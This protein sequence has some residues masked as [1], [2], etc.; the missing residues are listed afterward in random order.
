MFDEMIIRRLI[1]DG[2][3]REATGDEMSR[4]IV[5]SMAGGRATIHGTS[6]DDG[7]WDGTFRLDDFDR[8]RHAALALFECVAADLDMDDGHLTELID[9]RDLDDDGWRML[10]AAIAAD[11]FEGS[12]LGE[13]HE[14]GMIEGD[15]VEVHFSASQLD[16]LRESLGDEGWR[17][18]VGTRRGFEKWTP[19][20]DNPSGGEGVVIRDGVAVHWVARDEDV[21]MK[22]C[23][24]SSGPEAIRFAGSPTFT[25]SFKLKD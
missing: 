9:V 4:V 19:N 11:T 13:L 21:Y 3:T 6:T 8:G 20:G 10:T 18:A 5:A 12:T 24:G 17:V 25:R 14:L 22:P 15:V 23:G 7:T 1:A 2:Y 16:Q